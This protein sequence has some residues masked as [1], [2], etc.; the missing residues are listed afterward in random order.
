MKFILQLFNRREKV[1]MFGI[2]LL[3]LISGFLEMVGLGMIFPFIG[4]VTNPKI[5]H[6]NNLL[7]FFYDILSFQS[8]QNFLIAFG[9]ALI[10]LLVI[11]NIYYFL[12]MFIQQNY[13]IRK[14]VQIG[15]LLYS[16]YLRS[17]YNFHLQHNSALLLRNTS[18]VDNIFAGGLQPLFLI[19]SETVIV[20]FVLAMLLFTNYL[21]TICAA[22]FIIPLVWVIY[23]MFRVRLRGLGK[24]SHKLMG[25]T[26]KAIPE[27]FGAIKEVLV[28]NCQDYFSREYEENTKKLGIIRRDN[29]I[30]TQT[31][32]LVLEP[33][34]AGSLILL[35]V[36]FI[37]KGKVGSDVF[38]TIAMFATASFRLVV[39]A[40]KIVTAMH[41]LDFN[42]VLE[43]TICKE[44]KLFIQNSEKDNLKEGKLV[45]TKKASFNSTIELRNI[46]FR[47]SGGN[48]DAVRNVSLT[49]NKGQSIAF[50]GASGAGKSTLIDIFLGLLS[51]YVG[52]ICVDGENIFKCLSTW[53]SNIGYVPQDSFLRDDTLRHNIAFAI[54]DHIIDDKALRKALNAAQLSDFV[55]TLPQGVNTIIGE[56]GI[57]LSGGQRQRLNVARALYSDPNILVMDEATSALDGET[58]AEISRAVENLSGEKTIIII[59]HRLSTVKKCDCVYFMVDGEIHDSGTLQELLQ[60]NDKFNKV[61]GL[62]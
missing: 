32:R 10:F 59:A 26:S 37:L 61:A 58:E 2:F 22:L 52:E 47:Y 16:G 13:L 35:I 43:D 27:R 24:E 18:V 1:Q 33:I 15:N 19:L 34:V 14:R 62:R 17:D 5:I 11:K 57:R 9:I 54:P 39:S 56:R 50:V 3:M 51:P 53:R 31:P 46:S 45:Y 7:D 29:F 40:T 28:K 23:S 41:T 44:L 55:E 21:I 42:R 36:F 60:R 30:L 20:V 4:M 49:I 6:E 8:V 48:N 38:P 12:S 25:L